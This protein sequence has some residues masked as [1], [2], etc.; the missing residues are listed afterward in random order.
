[1]GLQV[2]KKI[3]KLLKNAKSAVIRFNG[4]AV[5]LELE[6]KYHK[7]ELTDSFEVTD[8]AYREVQGTWSFSYL[9]GAQVSV[10]DNFSVLAHLLRV[11]DYLSFEVQDNSTQSLN[12]INYETL[13]VIAVVTRNDSS[14]HIKNKFT[15]TLDSQTIE[16]TSIAK[17]IKRLE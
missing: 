5:A 10:V 6:Y 14:G 4:S 1:M 15:L 17:N 13:E 2:T 12:E 11:G 8:S 16:K 7:K 9:S 3:L